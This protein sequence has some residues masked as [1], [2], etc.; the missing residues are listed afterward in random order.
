MAIPEYHD[1]LYK[2]FL[3][4]EVMWLQRHENS[5]NR[6]RGMLGG[7]LHGRRSKVARKM[8]TLVNV[9]FRVRNIDVKFEVQAYLQFLCN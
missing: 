4:F 1:A 7:T 2:T 5:K 6:K 9:A 8:H 3:P